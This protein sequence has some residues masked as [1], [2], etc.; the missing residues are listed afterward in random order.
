[1]SATPAMDLQGAAAH[2]AAHR[3]NRMY[4]LQRH[5]YDLTRAYYLL[6]RDR[7]IGNLRPDENA[8]VLEIGCGTGRNLVQAAQQYPKAMFC[9]FDI[10]TEMLASASS[11][12]KR[13]DLTN[14]VRIAQ[15]DATAFDTQALFGIHRFDEIFISYSLS[16]IPDWRLVLQAA[17]A[18]LKPG[19]RLHIVDFGEQERLPSIMGV[20]I[21]RWLALFDVTPRPD[22]ERALEEVAKADGGRLRFERP[23][24]GYAQYAVLERRLSV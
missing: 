12:I 3:M 10:S 21:M 1:M 22:L 5:V 8:N 9:G 24:R 11:A 16:M 20:T 6:G 23:F 18:H 13:H 19:G 15:G 7:M 4:R 2:N 14:R 17:M